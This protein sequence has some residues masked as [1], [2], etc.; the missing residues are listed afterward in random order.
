MSIRATKRLVAMHRR[1]RE[2]AAMHRR[3][4]EHADDIS[5]GAASATRDMDSYLLALIH[6]VI[7]ARIPCRRAVIRRLHVMAKRE[8][9][10]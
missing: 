8:G 1:V 5:E 10:E 6:L 9:F 2:H 7:G 4:R 3:V